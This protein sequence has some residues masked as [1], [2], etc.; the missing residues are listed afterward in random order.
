MKT[1]ALCGGPLGALRRWPVTVALPIRW[2]CSG[3]CASELE[4]R[5]HGKPSKVPFVRPKFWARSVLP[6]KVS[7]EPAVL[8]KTM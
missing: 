5:H 8:L 4:R 3:W 7:E 6:D 2:A 1:C